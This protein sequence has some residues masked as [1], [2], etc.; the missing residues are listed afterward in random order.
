MSETSVG[1][2]AVWVAFDPNRASPIR[3]FGYTRQHQGYR[4]EVWADVP[5]PIFPARTC[6][7]CVV[8]ALDDLS[9]NDPFTIAAC[10]DHFRI[11]QLVAYREASFQNRRSRPPRDF[12]FCRFRSHA[13]FDT[14]TSTPQN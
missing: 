1:F 3:Q 4:C 13:L 10:S 8:C 7:L 5:A 9:V 12:I 14:T 6:N 11:D 2:S